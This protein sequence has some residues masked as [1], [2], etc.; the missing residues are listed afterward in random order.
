MTIYSRKNPPLGFYVYFWVRTENSANGLAGTPYYVGKG[1]NTR[2]WRKTKSG[3][4]R[5]V[6]IAESN[7]TEVGALALERRYIKWYGR[8]DLANGI[9]NNKTDGGDGAS[10]TKNVIGTNCNNP[11]NSGKKHSESTIK[12]MSVAK[13]GKTYPK[14]SKALQGKRRGIR[15]EQWKDN[16]AIAKK[17]KK[18]KP[19]EKVQCPHC[20]KIGGKSLLTRFH[21]SNCKL[22]N[23]ENK[24]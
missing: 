10:G 19:Q 18:I 24:F 8:K 15:S 17:G 2:A 23:W 6:V 9:L 7:L 14:I 16:I 13:T 3:K 20:N 21:F 4:E 11:R 12:S 22:L 1:K 5:K